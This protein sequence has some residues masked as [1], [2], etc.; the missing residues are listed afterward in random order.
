MSTRVS[1][2]QAETKCLAGFGRRS[3]YL[4]GPCM[5]L[6]RSFH[7]PLYKVL[8]WSC[9]GP[10]E[11]LAE[12][13]V[14]S[15]LRGPC[16]K[17][18]QMPCLTGA[19]LKAVVG[20]SCP[21]ILSDPLQQQQV[22]FMAILW[23]SFRGPGMKI[24]IA[25]SSW[26][27]P[28][29]ILQVSLHDLVHA[30]VWRSCGDSVE[31]LFKRSLLCIGACMKVLLGCSWQVLVWRSCEVL[32]NYRSPAAAAAIISNLLRFQQSLMV[33]NFAWWCRGSPIPEMP[34][35]T[36]IN[37]W[38]PIPLNTLSTA[39][40]HWKRLELSSSRWSHAWKGIR[41]E[42]VGAAVGHMWA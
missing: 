2:A 24:F 18:L 25:G 31:I 8:A 16:M 39:M 38:I 41:L 26:R 4:V 23:A 1:P 22:L 37:H 14:G 34:W 33:S 35:S 40:L 11:D 36:I 19:C 12:I 3:T 5:I 42:L 28:G 15:S 10:S 32:F 13:L 21:K 17:I 29:E 7:I 20:G 27:A 9:T 30:L 6:R